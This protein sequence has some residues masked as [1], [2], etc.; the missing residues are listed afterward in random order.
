MAM[1]NTY[2]LFCYGPGKT[3]I[4]SVGMYAHGDVINALD[5]RLIATWERSAI[6]KKPT[7]ARALIVC[8]FS[9]NYLSGRVQTRSIELIPKPLSVDPHGQA[10]RIIGSVD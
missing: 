7:G 8:S 4:D 10:N 5:P 3:R 1:G 6:S 2:D 9:N